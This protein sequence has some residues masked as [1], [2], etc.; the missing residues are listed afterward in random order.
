MAHKDCAYVTREALNGIGT[1]ESTDTWRPIPHAEV[2]D[3]IIDAGVD[4]GLVP[5]KEAYA[6]N[7]AQSKLFGVVTFKADSEGGEYTNMIGF[8]HSNDKTLA[9][10]L[11]I[12]KRVF[13]CDNMCFAGERMLSHKHTPRFDIRSEIPRLFSGIH[14]KFAELDGVVADMKRSELAP[15]RA[16]AMIVEAAMRGIIAPKYVVPICRNYEKPE[17]EHAAAF[18]TGNRW[19]LYNAFTNVAKRMPPATFD[20]AMRGLS[21]YF[22]IGTCEVV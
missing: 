21:E 5:V 13:V 18:P 1:P 12:G 4:V 9:L 7:A 16:R 14:A 2:V 6:L 3:A 19:S 11:T 20:D 15:D 8:R 17:P 22:G 10:S